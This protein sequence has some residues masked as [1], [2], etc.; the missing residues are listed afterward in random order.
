MKSTYETYKTY[1]LHFWYRNL[2]YL[3]NF[4]KIFK[5]YLGMGNGWKVIG[6]WFGDWEFGW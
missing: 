3:F 5:I 1:L 2:K 6:R 4:I